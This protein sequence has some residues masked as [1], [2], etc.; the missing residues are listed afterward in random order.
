MIEVYAL[1]KKFLLH[2]SHENGYRTLRDLIALKTKTFF[3]NPLSLFAKKH[4]QEEFWALKDVSFKIERGDRVAILGKNGSGKSTLLKILSR[5]TKPTSGKVFIRGKVASL[6]EV[7]TGFHPELSGREN[8][9]LNG[10][11]LGMNKKEIRKKFDEIVDFAEVEQFL[12]TPVKRY[13]SGMY[14]KLAF[15]V[16]A[17]LESDILF[18][19]E[20]LAVGDSRFQKKCI[21]K[22]QETTK[23]GRTLF[24]VSH[25][26]SSLHFCNKGLYLEKG[27]LIH[28]NTLQ[29]CIDHYLRSC[30]KESN[31]LWEGD[32]GDE[33]IR[34]KR[35]QIS[36]EQNAHPFLK[37]AKGKIE[38]LVE[39]RE[40]VENMTIA[41]LFYN[42]QNHLI[43]TQ[44][45]VWENEILMHLDA[46]AY[47]IQSEIDFGLFAEGIY[48]VEMNVHLFEHSHFKPIDTHI[49]FEVVNP[50]KRLGEPMNTLYPNWPSTLK[51]V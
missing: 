31:P 25:N 12:D 3:R 13:S 24:F 48:R 42:S 4:P 38:S 11:L 43:L 10:A 18:V 41:L 1:S 16:A 28:T 29:D 40:K 21:S 39:V 50:Q 32:V 35:C 14:V 27:H 9:F 47:E 33:K 45:I 15:A 37:G 49:H 19:D 34:I 46:G 8:I 51:R 23:S 44:R 6:L 5:I 30:S 7:G 17:H 20:V 26:M 22:M 2:H 36:C